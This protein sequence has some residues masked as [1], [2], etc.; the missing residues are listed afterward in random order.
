MTPYQRY[1]VSFCGDFIRSLYY[2]MSHL[3]G[4]ITVLTRY[5]GRGSSSICV[6]KL[7]VTIVI[8]NYIWLIY[9]VWFISSCIAVVTLLGA[10]LGG[11]SCFLF[12]CC[13]IYT[14]IDVTLL[15]LPYFLCSCVSI[16]NSLGA[17]LEGLPGFL[18]CVCNL[19]VG[20]CCLFFLMVYLCVTCVRPCSSSFSASHCSLLCLLVYCLYAPLGI[21]LNN[22][23][24]F[25]SAVLFVP[26]IV[27]K[28]AF[29]VGFLT[30]SL[31]IKL[32]A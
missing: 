17:T 23:A 25:L 5:Q 13:S 21:M 12:P 26:L 31:N 30:L 27:T 32:L 9:F 16:V 18:V 7:C 15:G 3:Y 10:N 8:V 2:S 11:L 4:S 28:G 29:D 6:A 14:P 19:G 1:L 20:V 24:I 22:S